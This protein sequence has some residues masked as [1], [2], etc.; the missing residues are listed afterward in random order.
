MKTQV[1]L[2][3]YLDKSY[4]SKKRF[5]SYWHQINEVIKLNPLNVLEIGIGNGFV[6]KYLKDIGTNITTLDV[7]EKLNPD[8]VGSVLKMPFANNHFETVLCCEVLEHLEYKHFQTALLEIYRVSSSNAIISVP[9]LYSSLGIFFQ[10]KHKLFTFK[11][12]FR[13]ISSQHYWEI[14]Y[15]N[16]NFKK[17]IKDIEKAGFKI[18]NTYKVFENPYH[19]FFI[20]SKNKK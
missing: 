4:D 20:L 17:I 15:K 14:G 19:V 7:D 10:N 3:H 6:S 12:P 2:N 1:N 5:N 18:K 11:N 13:K 9:C 8:L 16:Y